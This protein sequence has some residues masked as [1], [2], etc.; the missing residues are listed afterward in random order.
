LRRHKACVEAP[1]DRGRVSNVPAQ[2]GIAPRE[3]GA[4]ESRLL[5]AGCRQQLVLLKPPSFYLLF[6]LVA[7]RSCNGKS[8]WQRLHG[9]PPSGLARRRPRSAVPSPR[10]PI[11][12]QPLLIVGLRGVSSAKIFR[13]SCGSGMRLAF[14]PPSV[15]CWQERAGCHCSRL[16]CR[17][18]PR[19]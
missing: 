8:R 13:T 18:N 7:H 11:L 19:D 5:G 4:N 6:A 12:G 9:Y 16:P 17:M 10:R 3:I 1:Y 15:C 14:A 2:I